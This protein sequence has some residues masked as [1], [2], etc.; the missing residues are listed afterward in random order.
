M[1]LN[2]EV[3]KNYI[4]LVYSDKWSEGMND[5][6]FTLLSQQCCTLQHFSIVTLPKLT[7]G[8]VNWDFRIHWLHL[9]KEVTPL[10][11]H[12]NEC[13]VYDTKQSDGEAPVMLERWRNAEYPFIAIAP[14][15]TLAPEW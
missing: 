11:L 10:S 12:T 6:V 4:K 2:L 13:P 14:R 1:K 5:I 9:W 15:S 7:V 8:P 3:K